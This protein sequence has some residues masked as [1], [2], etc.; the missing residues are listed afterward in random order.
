M[1]KIKIPKS[2][3]AAHTIMRVIM[4]GAYNTNELVTFLLAFEASSLSRSVLRGYLVAIRDSA[5]Y[6]LDTGLFDKPV[7]DIVG[8]GGDGKHTANISTLASL[9]CAASGLV[10]VAKYGNRSA[11]GICGSMDLLEAIG[12]DIEVSGERVI[13]QIK[14]IRFAPLY[15]RAIYPGGKF[16]AEA[17]KAVGSPTMFNLLFPLARPLI[18]NQYFVFGCVTESQM[19]IV[20]KIYARAKDVRCLIVRGLD[21]TDEIS[22]SG[23]GKTRYRLIDQGRAKHGVLNC[24]MFGISPVDLGLLQITTKEEAVELFKEAINPHIVNPRVEAIRNAG[25]VN[26]AVALFVALDD[27]QIDISSAKRYFPIVRDAL[28]S[29][30]VR[31]L[32]EDIRLPKGK[33]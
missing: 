24:Q 19:D 1:K 5:L 23:T 32:V 16:V 28:L 29:G 9:I 26:A 15:A 13:S 3:N 27:G 11:S 6:K 7:M 14:T 21:Q 25:L 33:L 22:I 30:R 17:R 31:K 12:I 2:E 10:N 4:E 20:E 8:T 18:G